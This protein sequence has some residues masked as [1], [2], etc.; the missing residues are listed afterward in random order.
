[1]LLGFV[2]ENFT[3]I[4]R[5]IIFFLNLLWLPEREMPS[6]QQL[7]TRKYVQKYFIRQCEYNT[8]HLKHVTMS[9][10]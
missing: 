8:T 9:H 6:Y 5:E 1:M 2:S 3:P 4:Y 10:K 7:F